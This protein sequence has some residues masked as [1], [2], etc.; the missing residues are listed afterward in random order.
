VNERKLPPLYLEKAG[1]HRP[2]HSSAAELDAGLVAGGFL[3]RGQHAA[4]AILTQGLLTGGIEAVGEHDAIRFLHRSG[5][6]QSVV[7]HRIG[8]VA[9]GGQRLVAVGVVGEGLDVGGSQAGLP[10]FALQIAD[11]IVGVADHVAIL[12]VD[13]SLN[14]TNRNCKQT[15]EQLAQAS[16]RLTY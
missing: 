16:E 14:T 9:V 13:E 1:A 6:A 11:G 8:A 3:R 4:E 15:Q 2:F 5:A 7:G 12:S 10:G